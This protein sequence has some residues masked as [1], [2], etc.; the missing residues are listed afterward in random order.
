MNLNS[1]LKCSELKNYLI[2]FMCKNNRRRITVN[3]EKKLKSVCVHLIGP[4]IHIRIPQRQG[5]QCDQQKNAK[6]L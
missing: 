5:E 3:F 4:G 6:C 2:L 1:Q